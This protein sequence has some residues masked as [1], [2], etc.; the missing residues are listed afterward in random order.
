MKFLIAD[1][2][3]FVGR[4]LCVVL[5]QRAHAVGDGGAVCGQVHRR[6]RAG[7]GRGH[8]RRDGLVEG[9]ARCRGGRVNLFSR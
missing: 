5:L 9:V 8:R 7:R 4:A 6:C 1:A 2:N 3:G